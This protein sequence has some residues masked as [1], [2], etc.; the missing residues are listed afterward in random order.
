MRYKF[1]LFVALL[2]VGVAACTSPADSPPI[3]DELITFIGLLDVTGNGQTTIDIGV[4]NG[5]NPLPADENFAGRWEVRDAQGELR[6]KGEV[7]QMPPLAGGNDTVFGIWSG[8]LEPGWYEFTW[9]APNYG[10]VLISFELVEQGD[11]LQIGEQ[12][13]YNTTAYPPEN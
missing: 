2:L 4:H 10:S 12:S 8:S 13:L 7:P 5:G 3:R 6:A 11:R 1:A 9:G